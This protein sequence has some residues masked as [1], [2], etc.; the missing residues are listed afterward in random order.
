VARAASYWLCIGA[1]GVLGLI[2]EESLELSES[3]VRFRLCVCVSLE[4]DGACCSV[5]DWKAFWN[6]WGECPDMA[7]WAARV[8]FVI[9]SSVDDVDDGSTE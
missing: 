3:D 6:A 8:A 1:V 4:N 5:G 9:G 2:E 7:A